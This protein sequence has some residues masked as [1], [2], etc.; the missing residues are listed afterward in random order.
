M[1]WVGLGVLVV[2]Y[3]CPFLVV[4]SVLL[5]QAIRV[6]LM[7]DYM[8]LHPSLWTNPLAAK[9]EDQEFEPGYQPSHCFQLLP[10]SSVT[11]LAVLSESKL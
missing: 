8:S 11:T 5:L 3:L 2:G 9:S 1:Q 6:T 4:N 7:K 10:T